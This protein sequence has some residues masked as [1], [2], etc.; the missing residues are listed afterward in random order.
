MSGSDNTKIDES[1]QTGPNFI[2]TKL[3]SSRLSP[4]NRALEGQTFYDT[5]VFLIFCPKHR[6]IAIC[7]TLNSD[8]KIAVWVPFIYLS[9]QLNYSVAIEDG[10]CLILSDYDSNLFLK[11]KKDVPF[12]T[13]IYATNEVYLPNTDIPVIQI[14]CW[15]RLHSDNSGF[16]C[17]RNTSR[18]HWYNIDGSVSDNSLLVSEFFG[19]G[20]RKYCNR[21]ES[22]LSSHQIKHYSF[23]A[24]DMRMAKCYHQNYTVVTAQDYILKA[25]GIT[26]KQI[27][28]FFNDFYEHCFPEI[29][30]QFKSFVDYL[31]QFGFRET[32]AKMLRIFNTF[33]PLTSLDPFRTCN[34]LTF[35]YLLLGL[36]YIDKDC[37][38]HRFRLLFVFDYYDSNRKGFLSEDD[39]REMVTDI[40]KN[41]GQE[42]I[43]RIVVDGM[44]GNESPKGMNYREFINRAD[45]HQFGDA[46]HLAISGINWVKNICKSIEKRDTRPIDS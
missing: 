8:G 35:E 36:A 45:S 16:E 11:Y 19:P 34:F 5:I 46:T 21:I 13:Q 28:L 15:A 32:N 33:T 9:D 31:S 6:N 41:E 17:C 22:E 30:M 4:I 29:S 18:I 26:K 3:K 23:V 27:D 42:E 40:H 10:L 12:D 20:V 14:S 25:L 2:D 1:L 44:N 38:R 24:P 37:P 39:I 43:D 7:R